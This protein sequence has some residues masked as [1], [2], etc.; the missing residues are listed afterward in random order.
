MRSMQE[1]TRMSG[2]ARA[3]VPVF[4]GEE[5]FRPNE[6]VYIH[7]SSDYPDFIGIA[8]K[9]LFIEIVYVISGTARHAV[10]NREYRVSK[11][12]LCIINYD[13]PHAFFGLDDADTPFNAY[14]LMFTPDFFDSA[15]MLEGS[16]ESIGS[17]FLFYSLF[18]EEQP[19]QPDLHVTGQTY[20]E[21]GELFRKIH[22]EYRAQKQG[23]IDI[24]RAYVIALIVKIFRKMNK[25]ESMRISQRQKEMVQSAMEYLR[26][27]YQTHITTETLASRVFLNKDYFG[28]LFRDVTGMPVSMHLQQIRIEEACRLLRETGQTISAVA[29]QCG[30][31]DIKNFYTL[32]KRQ[33]GVTPGAYRRGST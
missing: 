8:H 3:N 6:H 31:D 26:D 7:K 14:D 12:D 18:P 32:F 25:T 9:H 22:S 29:V 27:H 1:V 28:K 23:Y 10:G 20:D 19:F 30:F 13:T 15:L 2:A 11:G 16:F 21:L 4:T 5:F 33:M 24:I 17:S